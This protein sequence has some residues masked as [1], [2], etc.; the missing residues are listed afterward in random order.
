M[1]REPSFDLDLTPSPH[2]ARLR[3]RVIA[4]AR[5][6]EIAGARNRALLVRLAAPPVEGAANDA[7]IA[8]LSDLLGVPN[9]QVRLV[10]GDRSRDKVVEIV[11]SSLS[12]LTIKLR[13]IAERG[14]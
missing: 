1:S 3:V 8:F 7:L 9:R 6:H 5:K 4:R 13:K 14:G 2:G 12:D 10:S 11:G